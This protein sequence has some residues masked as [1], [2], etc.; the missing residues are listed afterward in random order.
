MNVLVVE[1]SLIN[2]KL[3]VGILRKFGYAS[4]VANDGA[5]AIELLRTKRYDFIFMDLQMPVMDGLAATRHITAMLPPNARPRIIAMT[6]NA[7]PGDRERC[8]AAGMDDYIAKP[9]L[10]AAV[11]ALIERWAPA[12]QNGREPMDT[13]LIDQGV[14]TELAGL[15]EPGS[16]SMLRGLIY[17]YLSET[18]ATL[19]AIKNH[20]QQAD[21]AQLARRAHKL[22]GTS[23][24]LGASGV[25]DV[26]YRM[27]QHIASG[28][29]QSMHA[30]IDELEMSFA[31]TRS[32]F[33][34][35]S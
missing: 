24:S 18:P 32:E 29:L 16:P 1:D 14:V 19:G 27:E 4:D 13:T 34:K 9:I 10:P 12:R 6:A 28:D 22:A 26:C 23:A 30:L 17:Q 33:Q 35:L 21:I 8:L 15:D 5:H 11:Q 20:L 2:Q 7:L 25:A 3:A 31:R